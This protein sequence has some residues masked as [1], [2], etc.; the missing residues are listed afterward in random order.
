MAPGNAA[1]EGW[2]SAAPRMWLGIPDAVLAS[3][4]TLPAQF[5]DLWYKSRAVSPERALALAVLWETVSDLDRYRFAKRRRGQ[6]LFWEAYRWLMANDRSWPF[7]FV[8]L[9][10]AIGLSS[11][12]VREQLLGDL[13]RVAAHRAD[14]L[15]QPALGKAA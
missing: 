13:T 15:V 3:E 10:E 5:H 4:A 14:T 7:S 12:A 9:C 11:E 1:V 2:R 8:N 6:R